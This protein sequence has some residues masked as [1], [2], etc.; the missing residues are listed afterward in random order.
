LLAYVLPDL[1][2]VVALASG[3]LQ[4]LVDAPDTGEQFTEFL[5][6]VIVII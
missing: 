3:V 5:N 1:A 2:A 4:V 6:K